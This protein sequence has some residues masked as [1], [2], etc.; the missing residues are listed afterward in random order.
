MTAKEITLGVIILLLVLGNTSFRKHRKVL[1]SKEM[2][3]QCASARMA[4]Q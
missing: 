2:R 4:R 1:R 3:S